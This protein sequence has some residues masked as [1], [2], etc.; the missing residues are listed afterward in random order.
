MEL[1]RI[2]KL[3]NTYYDV[4]IDVKSR[5]REIC[6]PRQVYF[7][8]ARDVRKKYGH[9]HSLPKITNSVKSVTNHSTVIHAVNLVS[10]LIK[11]DKKLK[12]D[13]YFLKNK[14]S[15]DDYKPNYYVVYKK[16][17]G[18]SFEK[19]FNS[20]EEMLDYIM[21]LED[22]DLANYKIFEQLI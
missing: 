5:K 17:L 7:Y 15:L 12:D 4:N 14:I 6:I 11:Y 9:L 20:E 3:V 22:G 21:N 8:L 19:E 18:L 10:D 2:K 13:V 1:E 16:D